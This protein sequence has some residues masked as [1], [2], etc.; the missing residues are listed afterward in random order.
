MKLKEIKN[1][2]LT[3]LKEAE[4]TLR[5]E[6]MT[7]RFDHA[8]GKLLDTAAPRKKRKELAQVLTLLNEK[9]KS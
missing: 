1:L 8:V 6:V 5:R 7:M 9:K 4:S 3:E 2:S